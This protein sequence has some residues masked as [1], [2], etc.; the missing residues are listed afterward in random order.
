MDPFCTIGASDFREDPLFYNMLIL[1]G[2][3]F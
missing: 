3:F 1:K 2:F